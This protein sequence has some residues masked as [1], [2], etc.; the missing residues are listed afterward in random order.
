MQ[1]R[2]TLLALLCLTAA[3]CPALAQDRYPSRPVKVI[4][5][6]PAGSAADVRAR[7]IAHE[8]GRTWGQQTVVENRPGAGGI[9]GVQTALSAP[10]DGH[11]LLLAPGSIFTILPAQK[12]K[13]PFDVNRDLAPI[14]LVSLEG[15]IIAVSPKLNINTLGELIALAKKE[16]HTIVIGTSAAGCSPSARRRHS[17]W[18]HIPRAAPSK[19]SGIFL[20]GGCMRWSSREPDFSVHWMRANSKPW[21]S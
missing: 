16:P 9:L 5:P 13:L 11:T 17:R 18:Y 7:L 12:E 3:A 21:R 6:A 14:G 4:S 2:R 8:L 19:Q 20:A 10:A 15:A 1:T